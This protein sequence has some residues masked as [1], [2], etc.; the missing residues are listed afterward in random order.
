MIQA[1]I[2]YYECTLI[3]TFWKIFNKV[4]DAYNATHLSQPLPVCPQVTSAFAWSALN[5]RGLASP[6]ES[7]VL[8]SLV[9]CL[10]EILIRS[11]GVGGKEKAG[12]SPS[13]YLGWYFQNPLLGIY[14]LPNSLT[15][16]LGSVRASQG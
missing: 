11:W 10:W 9:P 2:Y 5:C 1:L 7:C 15:A 6:C 12:S 3:D 14:L 4:T 16:V 8:D 13:F